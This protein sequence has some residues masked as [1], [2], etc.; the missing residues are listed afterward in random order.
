MSAP[1]TGLR[2][3]RDGAVLTL[4]FDRP[5]RRNA[6]D[7]AMIQALRDQLAAID[8]DPSVRA[9]VLTGAG[10]DFCSGADL[11][12]IDRESHPYLMMDRGQPL[13]LALQRLRVPAV[14]KVDGVAAGMGMMIALHCDLVVAS[15]RARFTTVFTRRGMSPDFG[16]TW[17]LPRLVGLH[18]A[19]ELVLLSDTLTAH[20]VAEIGLV[21]RVVPVAELDAV[22]DGWAKRLAAGPPVALAQSKRMLNESGLHGLEQALDA[23]SRA[24]A[25]NLLGHDA[26]EA[27]AAFTQRRKPQF[28]GTA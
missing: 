26:R 24:Q 13:A 10:G 18:R 23:E 16:G 15:D 3:T 4:T 6:L 27:Y 21:N 9:V 19:K 12:A 8:A 11:A 20:E 22:V 7:A 14:A 2:A 5:G 1:A 17:L 25:V 28:T